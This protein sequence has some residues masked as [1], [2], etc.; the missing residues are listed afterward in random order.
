MPRLILHTDLRSAEGP[1]RALYGDGR[2]H[3]PFQGFDYC[4]IVGRFFLLSTRPLYRNR[5]YEVRDDADRTVLL[6]PLHVG[7]GAMAGQA[8]LWGEFSQAGYLEAITGEATTAGAL[9]FALEAIAGGRPMAFTFSR[10]RAGSRMDRL[11][12]AAFG[13]AELERKEMPCAHI[14]LGVDFDGYLGGLAKGHRQ[15]LRAAARRLE[16]DG[17]RWEVRTFLDQPMPFATQLRLFDLY[18]RRMRQKGVNFKVRKYFPYC[19]RRWFNPTILALGR[20]P[21]TCYA[22]LH[23][24]GAVAGFCAG[25]R[26][27]DGSI[28]LPFLAV[29]GRFGAYSPGGLLIQGTIRHLLERNDT[30]VLDL[31]RGNERYKFDYGGVAHAN[32]CY[33]IR[34]VRSPGP[35]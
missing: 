10:V 26:A 21:N 17:R 34:V 35:A 7:R 31:A 15:K 33:T 14:P 16:A 28:T 22:I 27:G 8:F 23:I 12:E 9:R 3:T 20:L 2:E 11:V 18:W 29:E 4:S 19:L 25:F 30:P 1:W 32:H 13:P 24:D 6:L 5:V